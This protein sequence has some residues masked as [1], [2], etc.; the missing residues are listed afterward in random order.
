MT[1]TAVTGRARASPRK[2]LPPLLE[3]EPG[4]KRGEGPPQLDL[5]RT[6]RRRL[7]VSVW[8]QW[9]MATGS[10]FWRAMM[11]LYMYSYATTR[12]T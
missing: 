2:L 11:D 6:P 5:S 3:A 8:I 9:G 4:Q 1:G 7:R 10:R 12:M